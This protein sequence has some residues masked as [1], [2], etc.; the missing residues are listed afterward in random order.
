[1]P[2]LTIISDRIYRDL[3]EPTDTSIPQ[4]SWYLSNNLGKL[5]SLLNTC[6]TIANC[7]AN[8]GPEISEKDAAVYKEL[9]LIKYYQK[10]I[11]DNL[12]AA[13]AANSAISVESDGANI[14]FS[15]RNQIAR[16]YITLKQNAESELKS[17]INSYK[18][19]NIEPLQICGDDDY[20]PI[21]TTFEPGIRRTD[22]E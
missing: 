14:R 22:I 18:L 20:T 16:N 6:Y 1:M 17:L 19:S 8:V 7:D 13:A 21:P 4:I 3:G 10:K 12:G 15:D 5:N 2:N 9:Y 11:L